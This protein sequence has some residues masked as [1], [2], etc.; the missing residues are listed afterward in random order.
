MNESLIAMVPTPSTLYQQGWPLLVID[1]SI[2]SSAT[3][4]Y[5]CNYATARE[6]T[7]SLY[8]VEATR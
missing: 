3:K 2:I 6:D 8:D 7:F 5:A 1:A 4:K